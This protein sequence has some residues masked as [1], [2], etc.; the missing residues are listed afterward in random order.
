MS[1]PVTYSVNEQVIIEDGAMFYLA[2][3][4]VGFEFHP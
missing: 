1:E 3:V 4:G 2:K